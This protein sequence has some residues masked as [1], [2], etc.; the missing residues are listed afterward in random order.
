M[1]ELKEKLFSEFAPVSTEEWMAKITADLKGVPFEKKLVWKTGEGFNVNPFYRAEDIEGLKTTESLPGE[2]PYVRGTKKDNDWKVRQNIEVC[3]FKG[4]N[5]KALDLLTKGV[6]SLGFIIKGDEVNEENI[7]TLLEGICPAS[8]ELN[9][10]TC[11]CKAEKLIGILAD[12][13]KGKGVDAEKCY[14]SVNYDAFKK[15][16]VKGKENSEWVEGA[17]AVLKAGQ[18]LPNYRVLAVNAFLFNNAGAYISQELGYALA[19]GNE[20]MAK[21]TEAGFT[22]DEVAKKIK[23]NLG[24][25]SNYFMEIAKFRAAR[26]L[27]AEIVAAYKPACECACKMVAHAQTSEWNMTVYDAHVNLLRSQT[28]AMSAALAGVDSI[29]VRP[30]DKIYQ[31]PDDFSERI[32]RNQQLLLKE[33]CHLDKVVDPS[34]GSYYVEVLT[35]SLA[36]VAWKLF[37]EV[38]EKGGFSV[39]VNAGEIQNAVNA[40]NVA[41]KKAVAT[42]REILLGSNQYPNFTEVAADKI[43]E[44]GSCCCGGGHCG[45]ATIPALD[46]SRGASEF[47]ALR[48]TTEKSGKTPKV[49]MLT[50]GNLAMRLARSQFSAN[51]FGCAGYKIIDNLGFDTVEAGVE[52]A[53]KAGAEIVVLCSS[54]DEY[55][56]FAPAAYKALAGRAEFV[57]AGAPACADDLKAQGIDQFVNVKSNVLETLKAFN[58]KLGIA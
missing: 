29:T 7:A 2:F 24:I 1:A 19:W 50:I 51:F 52:A 37:L 46:F 15:P 40:S 18:A 43:Q 57:V 11:N 21:L 47:E 42:R 16:L 38:E 3:C 56:E 14:G 32:A 25:S 12:Y 35:N 28:E 4:A 31:T 53:V 10:N 44:K 36:D 26:W 58:A 5:E 22:A 39:A 30:F 27:W 41:R 45:E 49:F 6:T 55:A 54:D 9:F 33:E 23:F 48:M 13:F 34:A 17:A 8:V 20:L